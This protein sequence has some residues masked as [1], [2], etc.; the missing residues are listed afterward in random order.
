M[1]AFGPDFKRGFVDKLPVSNADIARTMAHILGLTL[2][3]NGKLTGRV[4]TEALAGGAVKPLYPPLTSVAATN[5]AGKAT[6]L[7][8]QQFDG[9][10]YLDGA[11]FVETGELRRILSLVQPCL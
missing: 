1:V 3:S 9:R 11:C 6:V 10:R 8:Y 7:Q 4:L 5:A 2:P